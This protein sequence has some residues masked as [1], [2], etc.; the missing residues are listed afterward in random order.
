MLH[1]N[2]YVCDLMV[3]NFLKNLNNNSNN[4]KSFLHFFYQIIIL[5]LKKVHKEEV[6]QKTIC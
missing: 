2:V 3:Q 5:V 1:R 4:N 6:F